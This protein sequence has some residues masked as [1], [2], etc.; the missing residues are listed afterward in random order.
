MKA[1]F[2]PPFLGAIDQGTQS[3]RFMIFDARGDVVATTQ[4]KHTQI[5]P[6]PG[7]TCRPRQTVSPFQ[8]PSNPHPSSDLHAV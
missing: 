3:S 2:L 7:K 8:Q 1:D 4:L 6:N 5:T